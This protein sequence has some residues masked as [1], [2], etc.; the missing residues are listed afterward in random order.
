MKKVKGYIRASYDSYAPYVAFTV[1]GWTGAYYPKNGVLFSDAK[2][3]NFF[4]TDV[5]GAHHDGRLSPTFQAKDGEV[6]SFE[7]EWDNIKGLA[8]VVVNG[9]HKASLPAP[10]VPETEIPLKIAQPGYYAHWY[11]VPEY[12]RNVALAAGLGIAYIVAKK[13]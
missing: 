7:L 2:G 6:Y 11:D 5:D 8:T 12:K 3:G 9:V 1:P 4:Y 10:T 13:R